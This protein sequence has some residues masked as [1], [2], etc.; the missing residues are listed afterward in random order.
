[1]DLFFFRKYSVR[2]KV[3]LK[4][5][6]ISGFVKVAGIVL[7]FATLPI[8]LKY[9]SRDEYGVWLTIYSMMAWLTYF[10]GGLGS[11][12]RNRIGEA[13]AKK[14][15]SKIQSYIST[16]YFILLCTIA[17][18][19]PCFYLFNL[20]F[21]W[22]DFLGVSDKYTHGF[23]NVILTI[24]VLFCLQFVFKLIDNILIADQKS[25]EAD[26][27]NIVGSAS[28]L[29]TFYLLSS[30]FEGSL[31]LLGTIFIGLPFIVN[32]V[33]SLFLFFT[34]YRDVRPSLR[35][36]NLS[37]YKDLMTLGSKFFIIQMT[38]L[39]TL[40]FTNVLI[41]KTLGSGDVVVYNIAYKYFSITLLFFSI[42]TNSLYGSLNESYFKGDINWIKGAIKN[43]KVL[44][45]LII[46]GIAVMVASSKVVYSLWIGPSIQVPWSVSILLGSY[47]A[48]I[49]W[50]SVYATF[51]SSIGK[52]KLASYVGIL[53]ALTYFPLA[54]GLANYFVIQGLIIAQI[55]LVA[56]GLY[57]LPMQYR[58]L[59]NLN[60]EGVWNK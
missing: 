6:V 47:F 37:Y 50:V 2:S 15:V 7:S 54:I 28:S 19:I 25:G 49:I 20:W 39:V 40:G 31:L 46:L 35:L 11:G 43:A 57:W 59:T 23:N 27:L 58:K 51:I 45:T 12:L 41:L 24:F 21:S 18:L 52:V 55:L 34:R 13:M 22:S 48:I 3:V 10:D 5:F 17:I 26:M 44:R 4:N 56:S 29:L 60:A 38:S 36:V 16:S 14:E 8:T 32:L 9:L 42:V 53:N 30:R 1:M 33:Y